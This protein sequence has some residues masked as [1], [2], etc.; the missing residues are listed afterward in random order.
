[1]DQQVRFTAAKPKP[2][3]KV[4]PFAYRKLGVAS[5]LNNAIIKESKTVILNE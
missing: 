2:L 4:K 3:S 5:V 1:M